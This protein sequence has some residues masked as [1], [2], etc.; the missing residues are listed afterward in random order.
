MSIDEQATSWDELDWGPWPETAVLPQGHLTPEQRDEANLPASL[1]TVVGE[2]VVQRPVFDPSLKQYGKAMRAGDPQFPAPDEAER[3]YDA[4]RRA[5]D[6]VLAAVAASPWAEHLVLRGSAL[7]RAWYGSAARE[8]GDLD[9]V[10][11]PVTWTLE[12]PRTERMLDGLASAAE[13]AS[14]GDGVRID[15]AGAL[16]DEIWTYDRIPGRR[17]V[18]PWHAEGLPSGTV[19][20][21][22]VFTELL[23]DDPEFTEVPVRGGGGAH[24]LLGATPAL[25]LAWKL[26]WLSDD[27]Y[28]EGKDLYDAVLL[29]ESTPLS[30]SLLQRTLV[31][32]DAGW[33]GRRVT[34][35]LLEDLDIDDDEFRKDYPGI[36]DTVERLHERLMA[37]LAPTFAEAEAVPPTDAYAWRAHW[38]APRVDAC[39]ELAGS[40]GMDAVQAF[41]TEHG[42]GV[43]EGIVVTREVVG[44]D[45]CGIEDAAA[46]FMEY[47]N[48]SNHANGYYR[49]N[50]DLAERALKAL[51]ATV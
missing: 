13:R 40:E 38:L 29:A 43:E 31:A 3:W 25:S 5:V 28:P 32:G 11:T 21:D 51:R 47:R 8:P 22:F 16:R 10:V 6:H 19:Q 4:R 15:A 44:A 37:A 12:E 14:G 49:R 34:P 27:I 7:L 30:A 39:R 18:L 36:T 41:L 17:L 23:P 50:P 26:L 9:F 20:L 2:G 46:T 42:V 33:A 35:G 1:T 45:R 24:R 48:R